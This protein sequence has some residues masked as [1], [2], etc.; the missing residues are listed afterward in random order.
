[1]VSY[2]FF[3]ES[4]YFCFCE[5]RKQVD[6]VW[7]ASVRFERKA[8]H[9]E[10]KTLIRGMAHKLVADFRDREEVLSAACDL[11][12]ERARTGDVGF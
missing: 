9:T 1:M 10:E 5:A 6:R 12:L 8:D 7:K 3:D 2:T 11:A 4:S